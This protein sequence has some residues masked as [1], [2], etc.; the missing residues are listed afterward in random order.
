MLLRRKT[1]VTSV[2]SFFPATVDHKIFS[3]EK[4]MKIFFPEAFGIFKET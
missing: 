3:K 4:S 2:I 1:H